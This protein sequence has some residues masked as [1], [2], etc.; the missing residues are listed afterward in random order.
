MSLLAAPPALT[1]AADALQHGALSW[2]A[3]SVRD[4]EINREY[5]QSCDAL[6]VLLQL[7]AAP[8]YV[9]KLHAIRSEMDATR[10]KV[11]TCAPALAMCSSS[12]L[13]LL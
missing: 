2:H 4:G 12:S 10:A 6:I 8:A 13:I 7:A 5:V 3:A 9:Q 1:R 11:L